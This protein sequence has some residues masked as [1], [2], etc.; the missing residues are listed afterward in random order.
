MLVAKTVHVKMVEVVQLA[1]PSRMMQ[2]FPVILNMEV[3]LA[4]PV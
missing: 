1:L 2:S 4:E 3:G